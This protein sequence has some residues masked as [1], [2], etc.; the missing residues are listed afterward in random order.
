M[1]NSNHVRLTA[2]KIKIKTVGYI[3]L[4]SRKVVE[5]G[6]NRAPKKYRSKAQLLVGKAI[7]KMKLEARKA[8]LIANAFMQGSLLEAKILIAKNSLKNA[9]MDYQDSYTIAQFRLSVIRARK[10]V[11]DLKYSLPSFIS[12]L[13]F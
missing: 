7:L 12:K 8:K 4:I 1:K 5:T 9:I 10:H 2:Q 6:K 3:N 11:N 13:V